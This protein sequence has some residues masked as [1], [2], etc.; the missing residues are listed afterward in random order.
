MFKKYSSIENHYNSKFLEKIRWQI[1]ESVEWVAREKIHG[2]NF[3]I[4]VYK[5]KVDFAKRSQV[6]PDNESFYGHIEVMKRYKDAIKYVQDNTSWENVDSVNIYGEIAGDG[7]QSNTPYGAKDFYVFDITYLT[8][9]LTS[10]LDDK[11]MADVSLAAGFKLAPLLGTGKLEELLTINPEFESVVLTA[12]G[13]EATKVEPSDKAN[14]EGYVVKPNKAM[15]LGESRVIIKVKSKAHSE[16]T[17]Q[18]SKPVKGPTVF[19]DNDLDIINTFSQYSTIARVKNVLSHGEVELTSKT[20][21]KVMGLVIQDI[22]AE[23]TRETELPNP[24]RELDNSKAALK[25]IE[26]II[27]GLV[28]EVWKE[29]Q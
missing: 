20:F 11:V 7:V 18:K 21:G 28:R 9:G 14:T 6:I 22:I 1:E 8:E 16:K 24:L 17:G 23:Y 27:M 2:A 13:N 26:N 15:F 25:T 29:N 5:D 19:T 4:I 10:Y 12:V 3:Q